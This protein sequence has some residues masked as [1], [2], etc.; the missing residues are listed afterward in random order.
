M[1]WL[2]ITKLI[3]IFKHVFIHIDVN[4]SSNL[5]QQLLKVCQYKCYIQDGTIFSFERKNSRLCYQKR[6]TVKKWSDLL[7]SVDLIRVQ[8]ILYL[9][10]MDRL[11]CS[12]VCVHVQ[13]RV[14]WFQAWTHLLVERP[15]KVVE[16]NRDNSRN[17]RSQTQINSCWGQLRTVRPA[18]P[19]LWCVYEVQRIRMK[20]NANV[21]IV[22]R[23]R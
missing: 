9:R 14:R 10:Q 17:W 22:E 15:Q 21:S 19:Q 18:S 16:Q 6:L 5:F 20:T 11:L 4:S 12:A 8:F 7:L 13:A 3:L 1:S 2:T 23:F